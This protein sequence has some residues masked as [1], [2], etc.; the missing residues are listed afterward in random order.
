LDRANL[1]DI[2]TGKL[3]NWSQ[4]G[5]EDRPIRVLSRDDQSGTYDTFK[6][7]VL[8]SGPLVDSAKRYVQSTALADAVASDPAAIGFIGL[9]YVRSA[10]ALAVGEPG[11]PAMLPTRFTVTTEG[12]MLTRRLYLYTLPTPRTPWATELVGFAL[13]RRGQEVVAKSQFLDLAVTIREVPCN[14]SCPPRYAATVAKAQRASLD[15]R[16]R[17]GSNEPDSRAR[18]DLDRFVSF[19]GDEHRDAHVLL[20]GFSDAVGGFKDNAALSLKRAQAIEQELVRRG[21]HPVVVTGF[22]PGMPVASNTDDTGR[23]RNR[24]VEVWLE[25]P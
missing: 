10:K 5:G 9:P 4:L 6:H 16:F 25:S 1:H 14:A 17:S 20:L 2:F 15:F 21:V 24:R 7:L 3:H 18:S 19:L 11:A 12:Y 23:Q 13:S 22:G 8:G